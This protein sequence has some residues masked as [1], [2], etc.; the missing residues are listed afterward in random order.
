MGTFDEVLTQVIDML[1]REGR[2]AYRVLK[3]RF[4]LDDE[5]IE[6]L[7]AD[8]IDAKRLAVDED[9]KV[10]VW[11][12]KGINGE[13]ENE[14]EKA[15]GVKG[16]KERDTEPRTPHSA[17]SAAER[18]QLTVMFCDVVGS[19]ALSTQLDPEELREVIQAYRETCATVIRSF[20]GYLAKYIGDGLLV[21]FGY[22]LAHEDDAQRAVRTAL[23]IVESIQHLSF[24]TVQL[25][26]PLQ[27]RIGIHTGLVVAGEMGVGDQ[28]EPLAIVGET[29]NIAARLQEM[30]APNTVVISGA[31]RRLVQGLFDCQDRGPQELKGLSI[32]LPVYR[33]VGESGA[34]SRFEVAIRTGL[35]P[36]IGRVH[37]M[38]FLQKRWEKAEQGEGQAVMLSG[39]PGIGKSRL[40]QQLTEQ[41][42][43]EGVTRIEFRCSPYHQNSA[44]YPI[45][46]HLQRL[47]RFARED[48]PATKLEKLQH[49]LSHYHF[50]QAETL[51]LLAGLLSLP[52]PEGSPPITGS[53][54]KQKEKMQAALVA[55]L[56]EE[57]EQNTVYTIWED[58]HWVDPSTLEVLNL[59]IDKA[60]TVHL[61][62]LLTFR[63]EF[64]P[65]WGDR[66][67]VS[68]VTL[69][70]LGRSEVETMVERM[71]GGKALP[72]EVVQQIVNKTDGVPLFVEELT[73]TVLESDRDVGAR[74]AVPLQALGIPAT[75]QDALMARL[76]RLGT[77]KEI[78][79]LGATIGR[80]FSYELLHA[81]SFVSDETLQHGLKQLVEKDLVY[82]SGVPLQA[83]YLFKHAL[84]Q[85]SAY[86][87]L[88][89]ST[90][91]QYHQQIAQVLDQRFPETKDT[92]PELLARHYTEA[93]FSAQ[94]IP[95]WQ[96]AGQRAVARSA[97]V[98]AISHLTKGLELLKTLPATP[99]RLPQELRLQLAFT[100]LMATRGW[101]APAVEKTYARARELC[102]QLGETPQLFPV[103]WGLYAFYHVRA[104]YKQERELA[105]QLLSLAQRVDDPALLLLAHFALGDTLFW[106]GE[107]AS[108]RAHL[109]QTI[110]LYDPQQHQSLALL[111]GQDPG[112]ASRNYTALTLW[113]L[114]YPDQALKRVHEA[115]TLAREH[116]HPYSLAFART[117]AA[118]LHQFRREERACQEW[119]EAT[120][121]LCTEQGFPFFLPG[122]IALQGW[123]RAKQE[124]GEEGITQIHQSLATCHAI[125][126]ELAKPNLFARLAEAYEEMGQVGEGLSAL[127]EALALVEK[128]GKRMN[129]AELYRIKGELTLIQSRVQSLG[130]SVQ[131]EA[132]ECFLKAIEIAQRQQ[133]KSLELRATMSL[134]RLWQQQGKRHEAHNL[135]LE[136]YNW[137]TEGFNTKD[138]Q[139]AKVLLDELSH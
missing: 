77:A 46:D 14:G 130:S 13:G 99:D 47:L 4:A 96:Q 39:E 17:L 65:A 32:P 122:G 90:R 56:V 35:T 120:I 100:P 131:K 54:Q 48:S 55:W 24:P 58:L 74:H 97:H 16:E 135:L 7:K 134:A 116:A 109:E 87:S 127:A 34:Q 42:G 92:Q 52:H 30:A 101:G 22:P 105:E 95:Y 139:E 67:H 10:L 37:E 6:D 94:A 82:Q 50:P 72:S 2:V 89:K 9:S 88:L 118:M 71:T 23:G 68:Q 136:I 107:F 8:L 38:E 60:P 104:E 69:S 113:H 51:P 78:A 126:V 20:E 18:R 138:L 81:V 5:Y 117:V 125:G 61:Y 75:L 106:C 45:I 70:R 28:P 57:A 132:E 110:A 119:A 33:V 84:I 26:R 103:L 73:K 76:D 85:D 66:A 114:G 123:A 15:K 19:T 83:R 29:P 124:Q 111:Y 86:Q 44:L 137:F 3:R 43:H 1:Q 121:A 102:R 59:V 64:A 108:A 36:L 128:T 63:P 41:L 31:T 93:G 115:L 79:Q 11:V 91:Q 62:M 80:E 112:V 98:E 21:Y 129:E 133:A 49:T 53:P 27:V 40:V 12:G 25:P